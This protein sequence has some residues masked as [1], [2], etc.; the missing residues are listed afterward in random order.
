MMARGSFMTLVPAGLEMPREGE[1]Q[2]DK[3]SLYCVDPTDGHG[4]FAIVSPHRPGPKVLTNDKRR[5]LA[6]MVV[7]VDKKAPPFRERLE[8]DIAINDDLI[9]HAEARSLNVKG[10]DEVFIH[11]L[12]FSL[13]LPTPTDFDND[14]LREASTVEPIFE[15]GDLAMRSNVSDVQ[16]K[17]LVP[18]EVLYRFEPRYF[19]TERKPPQIQIE[20]RLYYEPCAVCGRASNDPLCKCR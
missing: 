1:C 13:A 16:H 9:L 17:S 12:E 3:Y 5:I 11:D 10:R 19:D 8:M 18:G 7:N 14:S 6:N 15:R 20:E 4:K 2:K